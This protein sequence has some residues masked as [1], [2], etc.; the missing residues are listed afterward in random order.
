MWKDSTISKGSLKLRLMSEETT[1]DREWR[2][3]KCKEHEGKMVAILKD[4]IKDN[5]NVTKR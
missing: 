1:D 5:P 2:E 4:A 3:S